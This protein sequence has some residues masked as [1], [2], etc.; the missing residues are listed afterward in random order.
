MSESGLTEEQVI[1]GFLSTVCSR[2]K[3]AS[4]L[5]WAIINKSL[6]EVS[7][8]YKAEM[9]QSLQWKFRP[10][11]C[12]ME[13]DKVATVSFRGYEVIRKIEFYGEESK[14]KKGLFYNRMELSRLSRLLEQYGESIL[15]FELTSNAI[16][17]DLHA[18]VKF[19][20]QKYGLWDLVEQ[21]QNV[22][23]A[24]TVDGGELAWKL[25]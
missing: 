10:W 8:H 14:Y 4:H 3:F 13:L 20:L 17:F 11:V 2:N 6:P 5:F 9:Y 15:P 24:A 25:T 18:A 1:E 7:A 12:L 21:K 16:K 22:I 19:I 23:V